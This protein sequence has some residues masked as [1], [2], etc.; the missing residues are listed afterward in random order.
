VCAVYEVLCS[1]SDG[2]YIELGNYLVFV[3]EKGRLMLATRVSHRRQREAHT[4][5]ARL[6]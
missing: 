4:S 1:F 3:E 5:Y 2:H 6:A